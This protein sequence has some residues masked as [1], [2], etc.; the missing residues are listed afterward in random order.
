MKPS[1]LRTADLLKNSHGICCSCL[2]GG[3]LAM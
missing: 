3:S 2:I 1:F